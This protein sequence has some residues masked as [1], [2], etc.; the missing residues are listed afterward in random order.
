VVRTSPIRGDRREV[1]SKSE[2]PL[3]LR[4]GEALLV[5][6]SQNWNEA[7][8]YLGRDQIRSLQV[9][10]AE[11]T[12]HLH[13]LETLASRG[14]RDAV[15]L[16]EDRVLLTTGAELV[17]VDLRDGRPA[18]WTVESAGDLHE[19]SWFGERVV[20]SNTA[21]DEIV[22]IDDQGTVTART[23]L[24][25]FRHASARPI[26]HG[27]P[28]GGLVPIGPKPVHD[29]SFHVNQG[30]LNER[31]ELFALVHHVEG[32]R[33]MTH[34]GHRLT[35]HGGGGVLDVANG[36][37][38][39]LGLRAPHSLRP[40]PGGGYALLDSGRAHAVRYDAAWQELDRWPTTGWGRGLTI[41]DDGRWFVGLSA[42]RRRYAGAGESN[43]ENWVAA[44]DDDGVE[45]GR[46]QLPDVEQ[47]WSVRL[48][49]DAFAS[50][51]IDRF[52]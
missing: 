48:I 29:D 50:R 37:T 34:L 42:T 22:E 43:D 16:D 45:I 49:D 6:G 17:M 51:L 52:A 2:V 3:P 11:G 9:L 10:T 36:V 47:V 27:R 25:P 26:A 5:G 13:G 12:V 32:Y 23:S 7:D 38:H 46:C 35:R 39:H 4:P 21:F 40:H 18:S 19:L 20:V 41:T 30:H 8:R 33:P 31:G 24:A 1:T 15:G 14:I 44:F 28:A